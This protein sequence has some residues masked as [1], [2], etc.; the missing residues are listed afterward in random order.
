MSR[1]WP[2][3]VY[4]GGP[5]RGSA[6]YSDLAYDRKGETLKALCRTLVEDSDG[7][8]W[9]W[10][11]DEKADFAEHVL[12]VDT[13]AG[14]VSFHSTDRFDGPDYPNRW[15]GVRDISHVRILLWCDQLLGAKGQE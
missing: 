3:K 15:D 4:R 9:G 7:T 6:S 10:G 13:P 14:Q 8:R 5:D 12:Y 2:L 11:I 1:S